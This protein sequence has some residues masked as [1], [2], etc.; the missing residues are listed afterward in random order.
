MN[1]TSVI[2]LSLTICIDSFIL[3]LLSKTKKK[4][5]LFL[6]PFIFSFSQILFL[7]IGYSL[8]SFIEIYLKDYLK[9]IVFFIFSFM[10]LKLIIDT[11]VSKDKEE[12]SLNSLTSI[13]IQAILT[14]FDS[15]FLG[16]PLAFN[17]SKYHI[18]ILILGITTFFI[19]LLALLLRNKLS[20]KYEEK[21]NLIGAIIL[22]FFAF[23][24]II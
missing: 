16:M 20:N 4:R 14:S 13:T 17:S 5:H 3:C 24:S 1:I 2:L 11:F 9:Y 10:S 19:C 23:K 12:D 22:L 6:I 7:Y 18:F 8:G 21:I 15:L